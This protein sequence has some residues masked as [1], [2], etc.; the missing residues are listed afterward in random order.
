MGGGLDCFPPRSVLAVAS[1]GG[2]GA[3]SLI[4]LILRER[5]LTGE[6]LR[7][8]PAC[9]DSGFHR[10][11]FDGDG[12]TLVENRREICGDAS[13]LAI[14]NANGVNGPGWLPIG[15][16]AGSRGG[17][18]DLGTDMFVGVC[19][20]RCGP[21]GVCGATAKGCSIMPPGELAWGV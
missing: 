15:P 7:T 10:V 20:W 5:G 17:M 13:N 4:G 1:G 9:T 18:S 19:P 2:E 16:T 3:F 6:A 21:L 11:S 12:A 14:S 8:R